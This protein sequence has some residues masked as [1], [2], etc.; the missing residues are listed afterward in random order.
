MVCSEPIPLFPVLQ[1]AF[2]EENE[3]LIQTYGNLAGGLKVT[4]EYLLQNPRLA[5]DYTASYLTI[6]CLNLAIEGPTKKEELDIMTEQT[7]I[8]QY[9][10]ELAKSLNAESSNT[11][12]IKAFF[13]KYVYFD[14]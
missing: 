14:L 12:V 5:H 8:M 4:E 13:H 2:F 1:N 3:S 11:T 10:L 9:L 6:E 7:I